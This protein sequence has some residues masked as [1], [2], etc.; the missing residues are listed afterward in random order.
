MVR[1]SRAF[2]LEMQPAHTPPSQQDEHDANHQPGSDSLLF[3]SEDA[4]HGDLQLPARRNKPLEKSYFQ[5]SLL[6]AFFTPSPWPP[7]DAR[8]RAAPSPEDEHQWGQLAPLACSNKSNCSKSWRTLMVGGGMLQ[9][10][11][12]DSVPR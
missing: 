9:M 10:D 8:A 12:E 4:I 7:T 2:V 6:M 3:S 11:Q 1:C 5:H